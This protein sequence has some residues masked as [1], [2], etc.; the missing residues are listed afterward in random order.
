MTADG[1]RT[2]LSPV[3]TKYGQVYLDDLPDPVIPSAIFVAQGVD[4][5]RSDARRPDKAR[6][7]SIA[8]NGAV[9]MR[10]FVRGKLH[11]RCRSRSVLV[12]NSHL[13]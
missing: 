3:A 1:R 9:I 6:D 4:G 13:D 11:L 2:M 12:A 10:C 7:G 8:C 5:E